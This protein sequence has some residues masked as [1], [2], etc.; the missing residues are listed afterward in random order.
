MDLLVP[1]KYD[2]IVIAGAGSHTLGL[3]RQFPQLKK[4]TIAISTP[5]PTL[6]NLGGVPVI[7]ENELSTLDFDAILISSKNYEY[8]IYQRLR[9]RGFP[10]KKI[11]RLYNSTS[12]L[13]GRVK[14]F[15]SFRNRKSTK[16]VIKENCWE[17]YRDYIRIH[18]TAI[19]DPAAKIKIF[20]PPE[21]AKICLEIGAGSHIY[22]SFTLLRPDAK[23]QIGENCQLGGSTFIAAESIEVGNDVLI[24]WG[25][26]IIDNDSHPIDW[27]HRKN[28]VVQCYN[29]YLIDTENFIKNKDWSCIA[30][31]PVKIGN[32]VWLGFNVSVLKGVKVGNNAVAGAGA[33]VV[34][35]V[36]PYA[37]VFGNPAKIIKML[38]KKTENHKS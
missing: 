13:L 14:T 36:P 18:P 16:V 27:E 32:R 20:N 24:A 37:V 1:D 23:I 26:T 2:R 30:V 5:S 17:K 10:Q 19:I 7:K 34:E 21:P 33:V 38:D 8:E 29:D 22:A 35:K 6:D 31:K 9:K 25:C 4:K 11:I 28:D 12:R 3:L 15:F